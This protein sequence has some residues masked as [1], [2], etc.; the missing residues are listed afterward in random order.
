MKQK[1]IVPYETRK[2]RD[3][4]IFISIWLI[5]AVYMFLF[6]L[7]ISVIFSL[8][9]T[10][11][12]S[13]VKSG[14]EG[15]IISGIST[16]WNNFR[17]YRNAFLLDKDF[18]VN[19]VNSVVNMVPTVLMTL[20]FSMFVAV[21]LSQKFRG[22]GFMRA[23][24]FLPVLIATGPVISVI[25]GDLAATGASDAAQ[26][27]ALFKVDMIGSFM[28]T[29]GLSMLGENVIAFISDVTAGIFN[30]IWKSGIQILIFL[31]ALSQIPKSVREAAEVEGCSGWEFFWKIS[32]PTISPMILAALIY[33]VIDTFVDFDNVVMQT[34]MQQVKLLNYGY[35]AALAWVYFAVV[36]VVLAIVMKIMNKFVF[37]EHD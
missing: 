34:V 13:A 35:S 14:D 3:G 36:A 37:Y 15:V 7:V 12:A 22:Q 23:V 19:L 26:F 31:S 11:L 5:G 10:S 17:H 29:L 20:V 18:S 8:S 2:K 32:L 27:S 16:H 28:D 33:T 24:F 4:Y 30:L 1:K 6:P 21:M 25:N 9:D